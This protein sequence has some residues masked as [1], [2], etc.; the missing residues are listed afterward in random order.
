MAFTCNLIKTTLGVETLKRG[1]GVENAFLTN[2]KV[3][4][5]CTTPTNEKLIYC[6]TKP[7]KLKK[8][9]ADSTWNMAIEI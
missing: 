4:D 5:C 8:I 7:C 2:L 6:P 1:V 9:W 3:A